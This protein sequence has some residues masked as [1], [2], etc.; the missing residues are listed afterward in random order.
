MTIAA[1]ANTDRLKADFIAYSLCSR[2]G[3]VFVFERVETNFGLVVDGSDLKTL[4][5]SR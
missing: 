1:S 3:C 2:G 4:A 5:H